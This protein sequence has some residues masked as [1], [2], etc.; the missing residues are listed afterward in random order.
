MMQSEIFKKRFKEEL[1]YYR[2]N[3]ETINPL[4]I[5]ESFFFNKKRGLGYYFGKEE[6]YR[7][8]ALKKCMDERLNFSS[9]ENSKDLFLSKVIQVTCPEC[10]K[11]MEYKANRG[12]VCLCGN[13]LELFIDGFDYKFS[14]K[15]YVKCEEY[16]GLDKPDVVYIKAWLDNSEQP[17]TVAEISVIRSTDEGK[18]LVR[19]GYLNNRAAHDKNVEN[20]IDTVIK[21]LE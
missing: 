6:D 5:F 11:V 14:T 16:I 20:L 17:D 21:R 3:Q 7:A 13:N 18:N 19:V 4:R 2:E 1:D 10:N 15:P 8:A 12:Y 9:T